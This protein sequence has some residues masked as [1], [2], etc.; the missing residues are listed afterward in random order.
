LVMGLVMC[1]LF[2][3]SA[4]SL[5]LAFQKIPLSSDVLAVGDDAGRVNYYTQPFDLPNMATNT[6]ALL[7]LMVYDVDDNYNFF[8][9]NVPQNERSMMNNAHYRDAGT[10]R[11]FAGKLLDSGDSWVTQIVPIR[12]G[13]LRT[14]GNILGVHTRTDTGSASGNTDDIKVTRMYLIYY[15]T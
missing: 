9:I 13:L 8:T 3:S 6:P 1:L 7:V 2:V 10:S 15:V 4:D 11:Y 12:H 14:N 5:S